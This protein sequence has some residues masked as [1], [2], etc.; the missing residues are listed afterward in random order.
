MGSL[1]GAKYLELLENDLTDDVRLD[2]RQNIYF[3]HDDAF[4]DLSSVLIN[5][6][7]NRFPQR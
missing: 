7:N 1:A 6:L 4:T 2:I 5:H 3:Q